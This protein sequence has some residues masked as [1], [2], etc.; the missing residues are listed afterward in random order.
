[1]TES[2]QRLTQ[3]EVQRRIREGVKAVIEEVLEE[4]MTVQLH[5][6]RRTR[7]V[8]AFPSQQSAA[9]LAT[10]VLLRVSGDWAMRRYL[11]VPPLDAPF[12]L[13]HTNRDTIAA[14]ISLRRT[15]GHIF[16]P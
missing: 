9:N 13:T 10:V 1:M 15:E 4:E 14:H 2:H 5:A 7:V 12:S 11:N 3:D 16:R 8:G 6:K